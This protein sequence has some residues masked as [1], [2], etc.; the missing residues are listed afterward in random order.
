MP[1][2]RALMVA[3]DRELLVKMGGH[4]TKSDKKREC[5]DRRDYRE[6]RGQP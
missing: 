3:A 5:I 2:A 1:S 6:A 4:V